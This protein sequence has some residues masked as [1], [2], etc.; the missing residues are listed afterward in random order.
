MMER[1][2][3]IVRNS[4]VQRS[5]GKTR[6]NRKA[7]PWQMTPKTAANASRFKQPRRAA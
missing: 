6:Q 7:E 4:Q 1:D 3:R 5:T 2:M